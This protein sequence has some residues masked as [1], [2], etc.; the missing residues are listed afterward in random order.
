MKT[1]AG[2]A[3][4]AGMEE[5]AI[6]EIDSPS[7][8]EKEKSQEQRREMFLCPRDGIE[9]CVVFFVLEYNVFV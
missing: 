1:S 7:E 5:Q 2:A 9:L 6:F 4:K 8:V 3:V